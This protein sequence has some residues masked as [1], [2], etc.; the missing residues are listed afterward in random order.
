MTVSIDG[1]VD[2]PGTYEYKDGMH[3]SDLLDKG[4]LKFGAKTDPAFML[5]LNIDGNF[6]SVNRINIKSILESPGSKPNILLKPQDKLTVYALSAYID[7]A[8]ISASGAIRRPVN[9]AFD[10][11][12]N[13]RVSDLIILG[14]ACNPMHWIS[15]ISSG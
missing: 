14:A 5:R 9:V 2:L 11:A 13:Y 12:R 3:I 6:F 1:Q 4:K 7:A 15:V 8:S 10:P